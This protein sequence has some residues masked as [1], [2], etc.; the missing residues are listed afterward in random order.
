MEEKS[1]YIRWRQILIKMGFVLSSV[2]FVAE[3]F[4]FFFND[5]IG[6]LFLPIPLFLLRFLILPS[7]VN[8]SAV[9]IGKLINDSPKISDKVKNYAVS[10]AL[11]CIAACVECGHYV[12]SPVM[13]VPCVIIFITVIF[14]DYKITNTITIF[15]FITLLISG[16]IASVELRQ[17][18]SLLS[19]DILISLIIL[20]SSWYSALILSKFVKER[21]VNIE[22]YYEEKIYL[23]E[24]IKREPFTGLYNRRTL[25]NVID[26]YIHS[27]NEKTESV[28]LV[29]LDIDNFKKVNDTYG[30]VKGDEVITCV[31][32]ILKKATKVNGIAARY[33]GEEF[34]L[35]LKNI[36][37]NT[38]CEICNEVRQ[39][40]EK[41]RFD[42]QKEEEY[43]TISGGIAKWVENWDATILFEKAD[44]ALYEA[45][46]SGKN[47]MKIY[48]VTEEENKR[49]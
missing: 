31:A 19:I 8:F 10:I 9:F 42:F 14:G 17:N 20:L 49:A 29:M 35:V 3:I 39:Q 5:N 30:H 13:V 33:G 26:K 1:T 34:A 24:Q 40:I 36:E 15:S 4:I 48:S 27:V 18:D 7:L 41:Q 25:Y 21:I 44:I 22:T 12:F 38:V 45:K 2:V 6:T 43:I 28:Y 23:V 47:R 37:M 11:F 16:A 46:R 32:N